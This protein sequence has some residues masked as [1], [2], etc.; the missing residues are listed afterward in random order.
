MFLDTSLDVHFW[1]PYI[2][3]YTRTTSVYTLGRILGVSRTR[4]A[5]TIYHYQ[6]TLLGKKIFANT[7]LIDTVSFVLQE[8]KMHT[9]FLLTLRRFGILGWCQQQP[10]RL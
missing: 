9:K 10:W 3:L 5:H 8:Q 1:I 7:M 6:Y 2:H 4:F